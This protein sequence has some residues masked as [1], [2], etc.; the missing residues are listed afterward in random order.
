MELKSTIN[1]ILKDLEDARDLIDDLRNYPGVPLI[2]IELARSKCRSAEDVIKLLS[3]L[4]EEKIAAP[5][6]NSAPGGVSNL[7]QKEQP[8]SNRAFVAS[9]P[10]V[11]D[12]IEPMEKESNTDVSH[13]VSVREA[14]TP[15]PAE[16]IREEL[17]GSKKTNQ[18]KGYDSEKIAEAEK[19]HSAEAS[20]AEK[21]HSI[22]ASEA[23][24]QHPAEAAE[25]EEHHPVEASE[26]EEHH[27]AESTES[28]VP[29]SGKE[30]HR[31]VADRFTHLS[32]RINEQIGDSENG[33]KDSARVKKNITDITKEIGINDRFFLIRELF[34]GSQEKYVTALTELN[35]VTSDEEA[36]QVIEKY[37]SRSG[38]REAGKMLSELVKRKLSS[39]HD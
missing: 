37:S 33:S 2:Q 12:A 25:A 36:K 4:L 28:K 9:H 30:A 15:R 21:D 13:S 11:D 31:I 27:S 6:Q 35:R 17:S 20:E 19:H 39:P 24:E 26:A 18:V 7:T 8:D 5:A 1:I 14:E 29:H 22:E 23:E 32:E 34:G 3:S 10:V 38:D 16:T